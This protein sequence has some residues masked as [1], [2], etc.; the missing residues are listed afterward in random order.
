MDNFSTIGR[1]NGF[2]LKYS[3]KGCQILTVFKTLLYKMFLILCFQCW[4][5]VVDRKD[6][7]HSWLICEGFWR[8]ISD[9]SLPHTYPTVCPCNFFGF[10][11]CN[12]ECWKFSGYFLY[13]NL[14]LGPKGFFSKKFITLT[15]SKD[16][17][18]YNFNEL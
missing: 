8:N 10:F 4:M 11:Q 12:E 3:V 18:A 5:K 16:F 6:S 2:E 9:A 17:L 1:N 7:T 14:I 13:L 15:N